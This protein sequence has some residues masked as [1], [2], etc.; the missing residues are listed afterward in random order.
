MNLKTEGSH[1]EEVGL[2]CYITETFLLIHY[3]VCQQLCLSECCHISSFS[4][5]FSLY[6]SF[7]NKSSLQS[8]RNVLSEDQAEAYYSVHPSTS[9]YSPFSSVLKGCSLICNDPI[10]GA[11]WKLQSW[12]YTWVGY[13]ACTS[14][15][16]T[17]CSA[18]CEMC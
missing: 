9:H 11:A 15:Q 17:V 18:I 2:R 13:P 3:Q 7:E 16:I 1:Q 10:S 5:A 6:L 14:L 12:R 8:A 4:F